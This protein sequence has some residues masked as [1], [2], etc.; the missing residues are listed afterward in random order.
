MVAEPVPQ[1]RRAAAGRPQQPS[2]GD[3][4]DGFGA[5]SDDGAVVRDRGRVGRRQDP[6]RAR[7]RS[8]RS[9]S[10]G[11]RVLT[12]PAAR[13]RAGLAYGVVAQLLRAAV[14]AGSGAVPEPLRAMRPGCSPS[15]GRAPATSLDE[16]GTRQHFLESISR[17]IA[18]SFDDPPGV[19]FVDDLHWCDPA[20][21]DA[22]GYLGRR[23]LQRRILLL[24]ARRTDEP[25]PDQRGAR[26]AELGERVGLGPADARRRARPRARSSGLDEAGRQARCTARARV[27]RC[28]S[29]SCS[30]PAAA[31]PAG[32]GPCSRRVSTRSARPPRRCSARRR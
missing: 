21:L 13:R 7:R 28:S 4:V 14:G 30:P 23:L 1:A 18:D 10:R 25:D 19:V 29:P 32:C 17:L 8:T 5:I 11:A 26:L 31:R 22:L 2:S 9:P 12:R 15:W 27:C 3:I 16:P 6:P 24:G 20:S